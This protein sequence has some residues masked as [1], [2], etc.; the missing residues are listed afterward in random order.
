MLDGKPAEKWLEGIFDRDVQKNAIQNILKEDAP[1][2]SALDRGAQQKAFRDLLRDEPLES[3]TARKE[4]RDLDG[5]DRAV[6][7][8][9]RNFREHSLGENWEDLSAE[10]KVG[11]LATFA[12]VH[13]APFERFADAARHV[14]GHRSRE[15]LTPD[16]WWNLRGQYQEAMRSRVFGKEAGEYATELR[17]V[18]SPDRGREICF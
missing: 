11:Y 9:R 14:L 7:T 8:L 10:R 5:F 2:P 13:D 15:D 12:A 16:D 1:E 17:E 6:A 18:K 3:L 4:G